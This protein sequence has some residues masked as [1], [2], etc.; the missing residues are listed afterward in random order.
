MDI[1]QFKKDRDE[2]FIDFVETYSLEKVKAYCK[3]YNKEMPKDTI[4]AEVRIYKTVQ[5][6]R[7][8]PQEV[9]EKARDKC[10]ALGFN[11]YVNNGGIIWT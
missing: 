7:D 5:Y 6:C 3:K 2:A 9:K 4:I 1:E 8:I 10:L 11:P